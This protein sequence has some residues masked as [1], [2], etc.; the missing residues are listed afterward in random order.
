[1]PPIP[2]PFTRAGISGIKMGDVFDGV[3]TAY[4]ERLQLQK[5]IADFPMAEFNSSFNQFGP[6]TFTNGLNRLR[7]LY[8]GLPTVAG[9]YLRNVNED[10]SPWSPIGNW[11]FDSVVYTKG[12]DHIERPLPFPWPNG[13]QRKWPK[14]IYK[15]SQPGTGRVRFEVLGRPNISFAEP[16]TVCS[17]S[18]PLYGKSDRTPELERQ[19]SGK[20]FVR[21]G[22][23]WVLAADQFS[24]PTIESEYVPLN[25]QNGW[26]PVTGEYFGEHNLNDL[27]LA[28]SQLKKYA[29]VL[30]AY[31]PSLPEHR[32]HSCVKTAAGFRGNYDEATSRGFYSPTPID[33][34]NPTAVANAYLSYESHG[35][36][37]I[38]EMR[39]EAFRYQSNRVQYGMYGTQ[40]G[41]N[42]TLTN[43]ITSLQCKR[44]TYAWI[45]KHNVFEDFG[46]GLTENA[47]NL[48][49]GPEDMPLYTN[50]YGGQYRVHP[51]GYRDGTPL[52]Y[53]PIP[54]VVGTTNRKGW[55]SLYAGIVFDLSDA[56]HYNGD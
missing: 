39:T 56:F 13:W 47:W 36:D 15:L 55:Y 50:S 18:D 11:A 34:D 1:M 8:S 6:P 37:Y 38:A 16:W 25:K 51:I 44:S 4:L 9:S 26:A 52:S 48:F 54:T 20:F 49:H 30:N 40:V 35:Q 21:E 17:L 14:A 32:T 45:E 33:Y 29:I 7:T 22:S 28:V 24:P 53:P 19:H 5:A 10:G 12:P 2:G 42:Y 23:T 41:Q 31:V 46:L 3:Y 27:R 43:A